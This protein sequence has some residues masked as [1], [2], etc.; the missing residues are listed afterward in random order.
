MNFVLMGPY[1][2]TRWDVD[3]PLEAVSKIDPFDITSGSVHPA[4]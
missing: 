1:L 2:T 3:R 4:V